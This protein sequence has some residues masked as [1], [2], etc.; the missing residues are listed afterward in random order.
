M[1]METEVE[2][3]GPIAHVRKDATGEWVTHS[4]HA[5][6]HGV[7]QLAGDFAQDFGAREWASLAGLWHD[8]GKYKRAFQRYIRTQSGYEPEAHIEGGT[9]R[10]DH[11]TAGAIHAIEQLGPY[12]RVLAYLIAGH[13]A[14]LPDWHTADS[15]GA[16]LAAR[17]QQRQHLTDTLIG[18]PPSDIL[19]RARPS[20]KPPGGA[21]HLWFRMLFSC[22]V[23]ADFLDTEAFMDPDKAEQRGY[24]FGI[25]EMLNGFN[26]HMVAK[27]ANAQNTPVNYIRAEVLRQCRERSRDTPGLFSLTVPT[28]GGKT[29][30]SLAFALEHAVRYSKRRIVYAI[31]YTS[32]I[33]QTA[34]IFRAIFGDAVIEH[35][36]NLD[37]DRETAQSRL[38]SENWDGPLIVTTNVQLFESLYAARTSQCRKLHNLVNSVI[39]LDEA[40]LLPPDF[41]EPILAVLR[42]LTDHY[43]VTVVL[44]T[45]TQPAFKPRQGF[46]W[47]FEG[48]ENVREIMAEPDALYQDLKRV[49]VHLPDNLAAPE[50]WAALAERVREHDRVLVIVNRR[51][52]ARELAKLLPESVHLSAN[53]C[54]QHRSRLIRYIKWRLKRGGRLCVVSTQ[55]IEAGVDVDFPFVF[56]AF[57]GLDSIA[58]AAGR[59][60][61]EGRLEGR[62]GQVFVFTPPKPAPSGLLRKGEDTARQ[63]LAE[64]PE[65]L[66]TPKLFERYFELYYSSL[67][68]LDKESIM[69]LL[70]SGRN[71]EIQF[72]TAAEKFRLIDDQAQQSVIVR[73]GEAEKWLARLKNQGPDRWLMRKL[74]RYSVSIPKS[75]FQKLLASNDVAEV[76]SGV[77]AQNADGLYDK[78]RFGFVGDQGGPDPLGLIV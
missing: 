46:G 67:N 32:I 12:G 21:P 56:R 38:A 11:S 30:S 64:R 33:E 54:G 3:T 42:D 34:D 77:Y 31:P 22:L 28:G 43:G 65:E 40:Q 51:D 17:L 15:G 74:Q 75:L 72:R 20:G 76:Y 10:V 13:H 5:H 58:Q 18:D 7:A 14:G 68:D 36:S 78:R 39:V 44:S 70:K 24:A 73:Y 62:L 23:D 61:R 9:G 59:C 2:H 57:A 8:I 66:L 48:L 52:D 55:L 63:L 45:A 29:L 49:D 25:Q 50:D 37:P 19:N 4:L 69:D 16:A 53:L 27:A 41:L 6:L 60:N 47:R 35:H 1:A 26:A 71:L